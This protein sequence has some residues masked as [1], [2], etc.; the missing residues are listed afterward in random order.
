ME[1]TDWNVRYREARDS[2]HNR[3]W[4]TVPHAR[5]QE[6]V[7]GLPAQG[8]A[9]DLATGDGRN[10]IWL[11]SAGYAVTALDYSEGALE[12]A[13]ERADKAGA[14]IDFRVADLLHW[15]PD[16]VERFDLITMTY[17]HFSE[18]EN[19]DMVR[20]AGSWLKP[21]GTLVVIAHDRE[22]IAAGAPGPQ[23]VSI[24]TTPEIF[25]EGA[26]EL[27]ILEC[28]RLYRD[29]VVDPEQPGEIAR[30]AVDTLLIATTR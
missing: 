6:I 17:L 4:S 18:A 28:A 14:G 21:G 16:A 22:N 27:R 7:A 10:A 25:A 24:L 5:L 3:L 23:D 29:T 13:R 15:A 19:I 12:L 26:A 8:T 9:L 2:S 1:S 30:T 20:R 11:A